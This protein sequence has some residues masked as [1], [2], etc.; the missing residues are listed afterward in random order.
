L[1]TLKLYY[2]KNCSSHIPKLQNQINSL[3]I[4][5]QG[6]HGYFKSKQKVRISMNI[7]LNKCHPSNQPYIRVKVMVFNATF[8]NISVISWWSVLLVEETEV[9]GDNHWPVVSQWQTLSH[10]LPWSE[11]KPTMLMVMGTDCIGSFKS[12]YHTIT[13]MTPPTIYCISGFFRGY[14]IFALFTIVINQRKIEPA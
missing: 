3:S 1:I 13:T 6:I 2:T 7:T 10:I 9:H 12:N 5:C 14:L 11:F 8:N 4:I